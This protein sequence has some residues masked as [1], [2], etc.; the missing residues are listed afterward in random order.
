MSNRGERRRRGQR[1]V[2]MFA[3]N[4][5]DEQVLKHVRALKAIREKFLASPNRRDRFADHSL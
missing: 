4:G 5:L 1:S 2:K 3:M